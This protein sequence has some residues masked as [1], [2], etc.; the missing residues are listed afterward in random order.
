MYTFELLPAK[1]AFGFAE[2]MPENGGII[3]KGCQY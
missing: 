2:K 1:V 3:Q